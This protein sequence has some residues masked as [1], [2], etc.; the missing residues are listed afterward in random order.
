MAIP[1]SINDLSTVD[2]TNSPQGGDPVGG[3]ID[4]FLRAHAGIL[5]RQFKQGADLAPDANGALPIPLDG[6]FFNVTGT[7]PISTFADAFLGKIVFLKFQDALTLTN[8]DTLILPGTQDVTTKAGDVM[9]FVNDDTNTWRCISPSLGTSASLDVT[10]STT[11]DTVGRILRVGDFGWTDSSVA[12]P[13]GQLLASLTPGVYSKGSAPIPS[14]APTSGAFKVMQIGQPT[15]PTQIGFAAYDS[16][17]WIRTH[18]ASDPTNYDAWKKVFTQDQPPAWGDVTGKP[19]TWPWSGLTGIPSY[20]SRWPTWGE[21]TG[22]P[23]VPATGSRVA[24]WYGST[25]VL[26]MPLNA[27]GYEVVATVPSGYFVSGIVGTSVSS[28]TNGIS[29]V[30]KIY[31]IRAYVTV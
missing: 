5:A 23:T 22:K 14:D 11:D 24:A 25:Y 2:T 16:S 13:D 6:T 27:A 20:A 1:T 18:K 12:L 26:P 28:T 9:S 15:W 21:V 29:P 8:G 19:A 17:M 3:N 7:D 10:E 31:A 4:N 30:T